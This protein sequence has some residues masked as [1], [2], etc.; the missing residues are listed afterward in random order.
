MF[1]KLEEVFAIWGACLL[2][3]GA[4]LSP[5]YVF[6]GM[7]QGIIQGKSLLL[8][9]ALGGVLLAGS[10]SL[11]RGHSNGLEMSVHKFANK[12]LSPT[13]KKTFVAITWSLLI[14][15]PFGV[16]GLKLSGIADGTNFYDFGAYYNAAE[17]VVHGYPLYDWSTSY[18]GVTSLP[19]SPNRYLYA[20]LVSLLFV[21]F[22][23]LPFETAALAWSAVSITVYLTGIT[24]FVKSLT[25]SVS[26]K[27]WVVIYTG[28]LGFGPFVITFIAGQVTGILAGIL[29][30]VGAGYIQQKRE[31]RIPS[32]LTIIP[33][34]FKAYYAP[35]GAPLLRDRRRLLTAIA[36]GTCMILGGV[37]LFD[38]QTTIDYFT[39]LAGGKGWGSAA[40]PPITWNINDFLPFYYLD[41]IGYIVRAL[42]LATI[43][44]IAYQSRDYEFDHVDLYIYSFG[45]LGVILG[46]PVFSTPNL[47]I[48]IPVILFL[49]VTTIHDRPGVFASTLIATVLIHAHPYTNEFLS[50]IL[51]PK[52]GA[53]A[54]A[55]VILPVVQPAVWGTFLLLACVTYEY[56]R[57][58]S[59]GTN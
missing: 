1:Q 59:D 2:I 58:L 4:L 7:L 32:I 57:Q 37:L 16:L 34:V 20:P 28:A 35:T 24:V 51:L 46:S 6:T 49:L 48:T 55:N 44:T 21:P 47:T 14:A 29:C 56:T 31:D 25:I 26:R 15:L 54:F 30:L 17:R 36:T 41:N 38:I 9:F 45:L 8:V 3:I 27:V 53:G 33:V 19:N 13:H 18:S 23:S 11:F 5:L 22:A 12:D 50:S 10:F 39:V 43:A 40:D 52:L 42:F